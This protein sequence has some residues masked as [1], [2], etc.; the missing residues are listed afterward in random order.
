MDQD[1]AGYAV[2][3]YAQLL[4]VARLILGRDAQHAEDLVQEA[5]ARV[6]SKYQHTEVENLDGL[7]RRTMTN[8]AITRARSESVRRR[9]LPRLYEPPPTEALGSAEHDVM[10]AAIRKLPARQRAV[11]VLRY[12]EDMEYADIAEL[13][14]ISPGTAR[15][16]CLRARAALSQSIPGDI[17]VHP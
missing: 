11:L 13:L 14:S 7:V 4:R 17:E 3:R 10:W 8:L 16:Q 15:S 1:F 5:L 6:Y 12:F 9:V 2:T